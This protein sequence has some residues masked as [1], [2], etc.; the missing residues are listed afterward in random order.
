MARRLEQLITARLLRY[1][2]KCGVPQDEN[3]DRDAVLT[4]HLRGMIAEDNALLKEL[5]IGPSDNGPVIPEDESP[6]N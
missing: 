4:A 3:P 6:Q 2:K 1:L 5:R